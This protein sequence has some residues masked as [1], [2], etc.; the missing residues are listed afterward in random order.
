VLVP[1]P[2]RPISIGVPKG[3]AG[4]LDWIRW[5][6]DQTIPDAAFTGGSLLYT[7]RAKLRPCLVLT[8]R[9][10]IDAFGEVHVLPIAGFDGG[11]VRAALIRANQVPFFHFLPGLLERKLEDA[12]VDFRWTWRVRASDL[13]ASRHE[14][15]LDP[16]TLVRLLIRY[17]DYLY[18]AA[19]GT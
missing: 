12:T 19:P 5:P 3:N 1:D 15:E 13:R 8:L 14:A 17:R 18:L 10:E 16:E 7:G 4:D 2:A 9:D 6:T 11:D